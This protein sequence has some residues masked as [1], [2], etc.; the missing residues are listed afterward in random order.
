MM[1]D[2]AHAPGRPTAR[3]AEGAV[4][5]V[6]ETPPAPANLGP[7]G[8]TATAP[9][10][11]GRGHDAVRITGAS[12]RYGRHVAVSGLDVA[13]PPGCVC[14]L[15]GPNGAGKTTTIG[16]L[17]GLVRPTAGRIRVLGLDP[18]RDSFALRQ[19]VGYVP[20]NHHIYGWM[21]V[22][23]VLRFTRQVYPTWDDAE[24]ARL[25]AALELPAAQRVKTLSKGQLAKLALTVA[26]AHRP[27]LLILDEPTSGL[28]PVV[29]RTV[30]SIVHD[31]IRQRRCTV[32]FSTHILSDVERVADRVVLM[33]R[34]RVVADEPLDAMRRRYVKAS[35]LF[36]APPPE[37]ATIPEA[38]RIDK[39]QREWLVVFPALGEARVRAIAAA[40]GAAD[41]MLQ[42]VSLDD[43][44]LELVAGL[45][46]APAAATGG[47]A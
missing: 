28:D 9:G 5:R 46:P 8:L 4:T 42:P 6:T 23:Q 38:L 12:K 39:A 40:A 30:L 35:L 14:G 25:S 2:G 11:D 44:F 17:L 13:L 47:R 26:L 22:R 24:C 20:E 7:T 1:N 18:A 32:L 31:L 41:C 29:R 27:R 34:G 19:Q 21:K 43:A 36:P 15:V 45:P 10:G 3:A 16:M 37:G 33:D